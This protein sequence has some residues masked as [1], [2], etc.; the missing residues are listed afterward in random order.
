MLPKNADDHNPGQPVEPVFVMFSRRQARGTLRRWRF[1]FVFICIY[2]IFCVTL[3]RIYESIKRSFLWSAQ[4]MLKIIIG[5]VGWI[6]GFY[7]IGWMIN[8]IH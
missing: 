1:F 2:Q 6:L 7:L 3:Q 5:I 4:N 8:N